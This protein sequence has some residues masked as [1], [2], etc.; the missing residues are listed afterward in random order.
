MEVS[1]IQIILI[2]IFS[3]IAGMGSVL[4]EFQ[5][6]R[7][8]IAC[9]ITGLILGD[10]T[11]GIM[12][13]G[14]LELIALGWMNIGAA[15]SPDSALASMISTILVIVGNQSV[16]NGIAIALPVAAAG[17]VL[18]VFARTI[19]VAF[20]HAAD[21][22]AEKANFNRIILLHFS[23][24]FIQA[25]RVS[26]PSTIIAAFVSPALVQNMLA[27]IPDVVTGGLEVAGGFIVVVGYAMVL[28]MMSIKYLM[29]FFFLGFVLGGYLNFSLLAFGIVGLI[30]AIIY[31]QLNPNFHNQ[32]PASGG[33]VSATASM[34]LD[35]ELDD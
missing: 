4:D 14:T 7:P 9:T 6:H 13:G 28:N 3:S 16:Q 34:D 19:T 1:V 25:L 12:L 5:T 21:K 26:I 30:F 8:I 23:A 2:F 32:P 35:D 10:L 18:T 33:P 11:T 20:Q 22:E 31:V 17:Q 15:Q 24:L 27:A 29:P